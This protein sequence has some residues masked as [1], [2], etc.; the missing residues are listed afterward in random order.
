MKPTPQASFSYDG[1]YRPVGSGKP[2][3]LFSFI[4]LYRML[5]QAHVQLAWFGIMQFLMH[6]K[7]S[8]RHFQRAMS[9]ILS[10]KY[11]LLVHFSHDK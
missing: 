2:L 9:C 6:M 1:S 8:Q 7:S 3:C 10:I 5:V 4:L 11:Q